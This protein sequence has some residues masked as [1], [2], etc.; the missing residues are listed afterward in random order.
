MMKSQ[1]TKFIHP[2]T[3]R[4][5]A[6]AGIL[7]SVLFTVSI[8]LIRLS[9]PADPT[10]VNDW[11]DATRNQVGLA[12]RLMPFAGIAFLWFIGVMR[13]RIGEYEDR[14]FATVILGSG[15]LFLGMSFIA[16]SIGA[17]LLGVYQIMAGRPMEIELYSLNRSVISQIFNT[18]GLKMAGVF[19][20]SIATLWIRT[21]VMPRLLSFSTYA[22]AL[23]MLVTTSLNLWMVLIFP[24]WVFV[25]SVYILVLNFRRRTAGSADGMTAKPTVS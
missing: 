17:G 2:A 20:I 25:I 12:L 24:A 4:A 11:T 14:F 7:F 18:Y 1:S 13:D 16:M 3:P 19:M 5:A 22:L 9:M 8:V 6:I 10:G 15:L 23:A 21:G